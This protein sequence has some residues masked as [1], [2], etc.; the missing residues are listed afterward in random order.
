MNRYLIIFLLLFQSIC[1]SQEKLNELSV[2]RY[3]YKTLIV[4]D[5]T[6]PD[7]KKESIGFLD[8]S[9][10]LSLFYDSNYY[11]R[12]EALFNKH[13]KSEG[14]PLNYRPSFSWFVLSDNNIN[15]NKLY[16]EISGFNYMYIEDKNDIHWVIK[17]E[18]IQWNDF[19]VQQATTNYG[20]RE[21]TVFFTQDIPLNSGPYKFNNLPGFVVKAWDSENH[22]LF[23]FLNS[24]NNTINLEV[25]NLGKHTTRSRDDIQ[26]ALKI[27]SNKT[28]YS[29]LQDK[30]IQLKGAP[31]EYLTTKKGEI[32]NLIERDF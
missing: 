21:W 20:G 22:Y 5:K 8:I 3:S 24:Q 4:T 2:M 13:S 23:E 10:Q 30:G 18:L 27:D 25:F 29:D 15:N 26:K 31:S 11:K 14:N 9:E 28:F 1:F 16:S 17:Q 7:I 19:T 6:K 12:L 32:Q